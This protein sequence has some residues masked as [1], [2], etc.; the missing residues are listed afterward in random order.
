MKYIIS[1]RREDESYPR[2]TFECEGTFH[3]ALALGNNKRHEVERKGETLTMSITPVYSFNEET[4]HVDN[5]QK[6][7]CALSL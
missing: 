3:K 4:Y 2:A 5:E 6:Q 7:T 1:F